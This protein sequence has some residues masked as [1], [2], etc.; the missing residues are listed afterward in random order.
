MNDLP[1]LGRLTLVFSAGFVT[2]LIRYVLIAGGAF[3]VFYVW[4]NRR[5]RALKI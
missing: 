3:L 4:R 1:P 5:L 2:H